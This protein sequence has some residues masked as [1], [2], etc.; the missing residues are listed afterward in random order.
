MLNLLYVVEI[1]PPPLCTPFT[2]ANGNYSSSTNT[3]TDGTIITVSCNSGYKLLGSPTVTC[4]MDKSGTLMWSG[5]LPS[6]VGK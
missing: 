1:D 6:C 5:P 2:V 3:L 4:K